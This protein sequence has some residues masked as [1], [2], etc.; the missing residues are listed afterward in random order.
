[1]RVARPGV[2]AGTVSRLVVSA[3]S[4]EDPGI[5]SGSV[6][7]QGYL[8]N[9]GDRKFT[10]NL[11]LFGVKL[12]H[13]PL[14]EPLREVSGRVNFDDTGIDFQSLKGLLVG[15]P[16][17]FGGRWRYTQKPQLIFTLAAPTLDLAY[18]LSQTDAG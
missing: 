17:E 7:Y 14:L 4:T 16:F 2:K 12:E 9:K 1:L 5:G 13:K 10:G 11:E 8:G 18:L 6:R 3:G 15:M